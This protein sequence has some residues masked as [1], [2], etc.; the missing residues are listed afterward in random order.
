MS[1]TEDMSRMDESF[2]RK[3]LHAEEVARTIYDKDVDAPAYIIGE[4]GQRILQVN[5]GGK[6]IV[7]TFPYKS[8]PRVFGPTKATKD[9]IRQEEELVMRLVFSASDTT[10]HGRLS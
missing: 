6:V 10:A 4:E 2:A 5:T 3:V 9:R 8:S 1:Q 7:P